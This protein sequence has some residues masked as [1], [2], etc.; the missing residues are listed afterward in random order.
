MR[1]NE[2]ISSVEVQGTLSSRKRDRDLES[3]QALSE[4]GNLHA[5]QDA[6]ETCPFENRC[7]PALLRSNTNSPRDC[8]DEN[9][10]GCRAS[11]TD[12]ATAATSGVLIV[13][14]ALDQEDPASQEDTAKTDSVEAPFLAIPGSRAISTDFETVVSTAS[15]AVV[16]LCF[17]GPRGRF[18]N[19]NRLHA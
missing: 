16:A 4:K 1:G 10:S 13:P 14:L 5:Q 2:A 8:W 17:A 19:T 6:V 11:T 18:T 9:R 15:A 3:V 7:G 12:L